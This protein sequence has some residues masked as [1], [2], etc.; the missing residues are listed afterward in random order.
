MQPRTPM[1][2][3]GGSSRPYQYK[4]LKEGEIR[5][6]EIIPGEDN[7]SIS[8][9]LIHVSL[10]NPGE[11]EALSYT[12]GTEKQDRVIYIDDQ[13]LHISPTL[14]DTLR[15]FR[16]PPSEL[17]EKWR[18]L[19][20]ILGSVLS[21]ERN[22]DSLQSAWNRESQ[23]QNQQPAM[24]MELAL[25]VKSLIE[26]HFKLDDDYDMD[27]FEF[28]DKTGDKNQPFVE[29]FGLMQ[30]A[31]DAMVNILGRFPN[32][33]LGTRR[34][35]RIMW[36]DAICINQED[37]KE[38]SQQVKYMTRIYAQ[39]ARLVIWMGP[40]ADDSELAMSFM[41]QQGLK[42]WNMMTDDRE[43]LSAIRADAG[44]LPAILSLFSRPWFQRA[45]IVQG[46]QDCITEAGGGSSANEVAKSNKDRCE[47]LFVRLG[48]QEVLRR[49][50]DARGEGSTNALLYWIHTI[51]DS[52]ATDPRDKVFAALGLADMSEVSGYDSGLLP[53]DYAVDVEN[54]YFNL[55]EAV[56]TATKDLTVLCACGEG[57]NEYRATWIPD[58]TISDPAFMFHG[59][60]EIE[61]AHFKKETVATTWNAA[62]GYPAS[63]SFD[64]GLWTMTAHGFEIGVIDLV[65]KSPKFPHKNMSQEEDYSW[66]MLLLLLCGKETPYR[67]AKGIKSAFWTTL[68]AGRILK[69]NG[70]KMLEGELSKL[71][72]SRWSLLKLAANSLTGRKSLSETQTAAKMLG[73]WY[74]SWLLEQLDPNTEGLDIF[75]IG[76]KGYIGKSFEPG[77]LKEGD[78]VCVL[79]GLRVPVVLRRMGGY[80]KLVRVVYVHGIMEGESVDILESG[81]GGFHLQD[82]RLR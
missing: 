66:I 11:Y 49:N 19:D 5:L 56:V 51:R 2:Y 53:V 43:F 26:E 8:S 37:L 20:S 80:Y 24:D 44:L 7:E 16:R 34:K 4:P 1:S 30:R 41:R 64:R 59:L 57:G 36:I 18:H 61:Q 72:I 68:F 67:T 25:D 82:F 28:T 78:V 69:S 48:T 15:E 40:E 42:S 76:E 10:D 62:K 65:L 35:S 70:M 63:V 58:W 46:L 60:V 54:V 75:V 79:H 39:S 33:R 32:V 47:I 77:L 27:A 22:L 9:R 21:D 55:V 3:Q 50:P 23:E 52:K 74:T 17:W 71:K 12:W 6:L 38:R 73:K 31:C 13:I 29:L 81:R 14:Q 45:W